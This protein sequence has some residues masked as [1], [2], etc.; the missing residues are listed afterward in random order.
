MITKIIKTGPK[1]KQFWPPKNSKE[2]QYIY[3]YMYVYKRDITILK[4]RKKLWFFLPMKSWN[5]W[6]QE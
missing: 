2:L 3:I 5:N 6:A 4:K 1:N